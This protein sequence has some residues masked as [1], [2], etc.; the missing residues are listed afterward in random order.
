LRPILDR[1]AN[2]RAHGQFD[3]SCN[4][5]NRGGSRIVKLDNQTV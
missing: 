4:D 1:R 3:F 5:I 2:A